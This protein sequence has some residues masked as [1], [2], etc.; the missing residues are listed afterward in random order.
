MTLGDD[1]LYYV[2]DN[3]NHRIAVFDGEGNFV[4]AFGSVS[5]EWL[6]QK[7]AEGRDSF[8]MIHNGKPLL[9]AA[10]FDWIDVEQLY[11]KLLEVV[12]ETSVTA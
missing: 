4:R 3:G 9:R 8:V 12:E 10:E 1:G 5:K 11:A 7:F 2:A 6:E